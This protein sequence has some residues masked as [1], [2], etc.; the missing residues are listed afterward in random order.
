MEKIKL[1]DKEFIMS[2]TPPEIQKAVS[3]IAEK[4]NR[5]LAGENPV[6]ISILNG[7]FIFTADLIRK[8]SMDC[9]V[10]FV[11]MSSY[12]GSASTGVVKEIIGLSE[13]IRGRTVVIVDDIVDTGTTIEYIVGELQR[14]MPKQIKIAALLLKPEAFRGN[15]RLDYVGMEIPS[16]F[17]VG[18]G[19]DYDQLGRNLEGIYRITD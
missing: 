7:A 4:I 6:F 16:D 18:Y 17:I 3:A 1:H 9:Q 10:S 12:S 11:K 14:R 5:D 13:N 15:V 2:I 19:L 8:M